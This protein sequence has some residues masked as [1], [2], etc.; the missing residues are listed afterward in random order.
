MEIA[1]RL[2]HKPDPEGAGRGGADHLW[3]LAYQ[4]PDI[5]QAHRRMA[6]AGLDLTS[7]R[8]GHKPGTRV[9]SVRGNPIGIPT[10]V[11]QPVGD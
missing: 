11:I 10:L 2:D 4:V 6:E 8:D 1:S 5:D 7:I 9:C 3:G